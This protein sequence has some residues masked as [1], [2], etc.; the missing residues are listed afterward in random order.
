[1]IQKIKLDFSP[2]VNLWPIIVDIIT[3]NRNKI[4]VSVG[5]KLAM[6]AFHIQVIYFSSSLSDSP[7]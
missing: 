1:M 2:S 3:K 5:T 6:P 4:V 7:F